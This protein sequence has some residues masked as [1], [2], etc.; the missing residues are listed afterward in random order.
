MKSIQYLLLLVLSLFLLSPVFVNADTAPA[1]GF[2]YQPLEPIPGATN[3]SNFP[4]YVKGIYKF[5]LWTVGLAALLMLTVGGFLYVTSAGNTSALGNAKGIIK[6]SL[7]GIALALTAYLILNIISPDLVNVNLNSFS[8]VGGK[9]PDAALVNDSVV[10]GVIDG[11]NSLE[12]WAAS[13]TKP[14]EN[15]TNATNSCIGRNKT[16]PA[17]LTTYG[18]I[19][20]SSAQSVLDSAGDLDGS[21]FSLWSS[22][23][24]W[25]GACT[26][27]TSLS[28]IPKYA[29]QYLKDLKTKSGCGNLLITGGTEW[30]HTTHCPLSPSIDIDNKPAN[31]GDCLGN[32][33][34]SIKTSVGNDQ[35]KYEEKLQKDLHIDI[36][37]TDPAWSGIKANCDNYSEP[38]GHFHFSFCGFVH[39]NGKVGC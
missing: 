10:K 7:I 8:G 24:C 36:I 39:K 6:D 4:D 28:Q 38:N 19:S 15:Q 26:N 12:I 30:G 17:N 23:N 37:C 25:D 20:N 16:N 11:S 9:V 2:A 13:C 34:K 33:L 21:G 18:T 1:T 31:H 22:G 27:C 35:A 5:G 14:T 29:I 32:Y 3:A